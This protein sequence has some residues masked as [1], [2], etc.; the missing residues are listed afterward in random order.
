MLLPL[1]LPL[2]LML[3]A[4]VLMPLAVTEELIDIEAEVELVDATAVLAGSEVVGGAVL[5]GAANEVDGA[6]VEAGACDEEARTLERISNCG[7]KFVWV[8]SCS[9]MISMV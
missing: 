9:S 1:A 6:A 4:M 2:V 3:D 7:V 8:G 5:A